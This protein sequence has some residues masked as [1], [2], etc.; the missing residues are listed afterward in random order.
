MRLDSISI[1]NFRL[2]EKLDISF[3]K[4]LTVLVAGNGGGKT[5][6]LDAITILM[7]TYLGAFP[8]T[9]GVGIDTTDVLTR[10]LKNDELGRMATS[11]PAKLSATG[12]LTED[13]GVVSGLGSAG[14]KSRKRPSRKHH[15]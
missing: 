3:D 5:S 4:N 14:L 2:F 10:R 12:E 8:T 6:I 1:E 9:K 11:F 15:L 13:G 7:G